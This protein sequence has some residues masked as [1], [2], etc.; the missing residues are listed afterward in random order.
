MFSSF[1]AQGSS[2]FPEHQLEM[3]ILCSAPQ[4]AVQDN[5]DQNLP[6]FAYNSKVFHGN[7]AFKDCSQGYLALGCRELGVSAK[8]LGMCLNL[9]RLGS[10]N[11]QN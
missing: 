7:L 5:L 2:G 4:Q 11:A 9:E 6:W 8:L 1:L 10:A 3:H